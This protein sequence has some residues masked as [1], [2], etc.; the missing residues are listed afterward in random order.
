MTRFAPRWNDL[1]F[2]HIEGKPVDIGRRGPHADAVGFAQSDMIERFL[3]GIDP[4][5]YECSRIIRSSIEQ[6]AREILGAVTNADPKSI[7]FSQ[8]L[9]GVFEKIQLDQLQNF[10]KYRDQEYTKPI[11]DMIMHMPKQEISTLASALIDLTS[12]K[13]HV[14][15]EQEIVGGEVDVAVIS[16]SE[17]F[18][19]VKRKHYFPGELNSRFFARHYKNSGMIS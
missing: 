19:W 11:V 8:S 15:R 13:R 9:S 4:E 2:K 12:L 5:M 1:R 17:G 18:V 14:S 3:H 16:K 6:T 10:Q 7:V